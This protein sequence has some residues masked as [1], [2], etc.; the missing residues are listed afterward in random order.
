MHDEGI[1]KKVG[2][3]KDELHV[4]AVCIGPVN[5]TPNFGYGYNIMD[6]NAID[7]N[8]LGSMEDFEKL[9]VALHKQSI[10]MFLILF[11]FFARHWHNE[12]HIMIHMHTYIH[13]P[14]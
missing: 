1:H 5:P 9:R 13:T 6:Y 11:F 12:Q 2:Y 3:L 8:H 10:S 4:D 7:A 14:V